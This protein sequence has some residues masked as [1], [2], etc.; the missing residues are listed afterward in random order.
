[1]PVLQFSLQILV[2]CMGKY[3]IYIWV[4]VHKVLEIRS[5]VNVTNLICNFFEL[6]KYSVHSFLVPCMIFQLF[7]SLITFI[8]RYYYYY[9]DVL[10]FELCY[11]HLLKIL[12]IKLIA[13]CPCFPL[14]SEEP[15]ISVLHIQY[16]E[17]PDHGV[18]TDT[19]AV[20]E[21]LKTIY[22]VP[23][24]LGP[25]VVHC[26]LHSFSLLPFMSS[27]CMISNLFV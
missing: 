17:W 14:Q 4:L 21:I 18:P 7:V 5:I 23:P 3:T 10:L 19:I 12:N 8:L 25:V 20:R 1:M 27:A 24:N 13:A 2:S 11:S 26:R 6:G 22:Q 15:P 16:P 9:M